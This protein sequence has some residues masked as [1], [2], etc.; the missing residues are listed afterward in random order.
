MTDAPLIADIEGYAAV[1]EQPDLNGDV[2]AR[3]AFKKTLAKRTAPVRMLYAHAAETPIGRWTSFTEDARGLYARGELLLSSRAAREVHA[4]LQG[5][6][7]DGLSIGYQTVRARKA[8]RGRARR[9]VEADLWEV[10]VVT[11]PMAPGARIVH[12]GAPRPDQARE[13]RVT[14]LSRQLDH[15]LSLSPASPRRERAPSAFHNARTKP[16]HSLLP[17]RRTPV[18]P[19]GVRHIADVLRDAASI[20]SA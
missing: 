2:I 5:G 10:S 14:A 17:G 15:V 3:G 11:F 6:A 8:P 9:I 19:A 12:V 7:I 20:L 4:L 13:D 16:R 18:P 1:F